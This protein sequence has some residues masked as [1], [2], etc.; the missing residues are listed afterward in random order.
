MS[1]SAPRLVWAWEEVDLARIR[2]TWAAQRLFPKPAPPYSS[3]SNH[4]VANI[5]LSKLLSVQILDDS[6]DLTL[7]R[8][9]LVRNRLVRPSPLKDK[10]PSAP[11]TPSRGIE[12]IYE[13]QHPKLTLCSNHLYHSGMHRTAGSRSAAIPGAMRW[14][15]RPESM[16]DTIFCARFPAS[17]VGAILFEYTEG[18][19]ALG[20]GRTQ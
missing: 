2:R 11:V 7:L 15:E 18:V 19:S 1:L 5:F 14:S 6:V 16:I 3:Y 10:T 13:N 17:R 20:A 4:D 9:A 8:V 12:W